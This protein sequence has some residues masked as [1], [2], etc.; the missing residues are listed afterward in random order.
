MPGGMTDK[1]RQV[2]PGRAR[3]FVKL[4]VSGVP[5]TKAAERA[6]YPDGGHEVDRLLKQPGIADTIIQRLQKQLV[7]W[8]LLSAAA[9]AALF[10]NLTDADADRSVKNAAA[11]IVFD[12]LKRTDAATLSD[13]IDAEDKA[14]SK[15]EMAL[16]ILGRHGTLGAP[17]AVASVEGEQ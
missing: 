12:T 11:R 9:K 17:T 13:V 7:P 16:A 2:A 5:M 6:G 8:R 1:S 10:A 15:E 4:A 14:S 3:D